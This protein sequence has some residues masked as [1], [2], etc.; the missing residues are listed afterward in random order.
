MLEIE[1]LADRVAIINKGTL[2]ENGRVSE[3]K[4]RHCAANLEEVFAKI[5]L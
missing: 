2:I 4:G 1:F 3:I 5:V